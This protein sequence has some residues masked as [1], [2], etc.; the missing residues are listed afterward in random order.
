MHFKRTT[1]SNQIYEYIKKQIMDGELPPGSPI[2]ETTL[3]SYL[4]VSRAP[5]REALQKL[6]HEGIVVSEAQKG[7]FVRSLSS[8]DIVDSYTLTGILESSGVLYSLELWTDSDMARHEQIVE[9]MHQRI[10]NDSRIKQ[11]VNFEELFHETLLQRC[12]NDKLVKMTKDSC[13]AISNTLLYHQ[14]IK[15]FTPQEFFRQHETIA[16]AAYTRDPAATAKAIFLH[17]QD[18]GKS[19]ARFGQR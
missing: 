4:G 9:A 19:M 16:Q 10:Y 11:L 1:Y 18:T 12:E 17:Y 14:R 13:A 7:K 3:S 5:I 8:K 15:L 6:C 2:K